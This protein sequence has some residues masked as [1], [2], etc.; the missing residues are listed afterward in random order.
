MMDDRG[1]SMVEFALV[2]PL[3]ILLLFGII[4]FG[5]LLAQHL[6]VRHG[7]REASRVAAV[8]YSSSTPTAT[9]ATQS[10]QI[11][12]AVCSRMDFSEQATVSMSLKDADGAAATKGRIAVVTVSS[13]PEQITGLFGPVIDTIDLDSTVE[14]R[15]ES[16]ATWSNGWT[17]SC[18]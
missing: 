18:T 9:G 10:Q 3:F 17:G 11:R 13:T 6:D 1:S 7:A 8:N 4:E 5:W 2:V 14:F 15:L 16:A 12:D